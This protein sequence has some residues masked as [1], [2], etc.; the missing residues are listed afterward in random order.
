MFRIDFWSKNHKN[1]YNNILNNS[2]LLLE[3]THRKFTT[4]ACFNVFA[5]KLFN[6]NSTSYI[7]LNQKIVQKNFAHT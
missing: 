5:I 7:F 3:L 6:L 4:I 1:A 2:K